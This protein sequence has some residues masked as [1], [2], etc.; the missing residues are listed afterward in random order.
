MKKKLHLCCSLLFVI[1]FPG[2]AQNIDSLIHVLDNEKRTIEEQITLCKQITSFYW[3]NDMDKTFEYAERGLK[4]AEK[5]NDASIK[6]WFNLGIADSYNAWEK[7]D[8]ALIYYEKSLDQALESGDDETLTIAYSSIGVFHFLRGRNLTA[9]D[10]YMR[11]LAFSEITGDSGHSMIIL[12]NIAGIYRSLLNN[13]RALHF[14]EQAKEIAE[15][16]DS[17]YGKMCVYYDL[18]HISLENKET[19]KA[20]EYML[21]VEELSHILYDKQFEILSLQALSYIYCDGFK[22]YDKAETYAKESLR[23]AEDFGSHRLIRY[24]WLALSDIYLKQRKYKESEATAWKAW[25]MD[26]V[27]FDQGRGITQN[28]AFANALMGNDDKALEFIEKHKDFYKTYTN[29]SLQTAMADLEVKYESEKKEIRIHALEKERRFYIW[30][31][32]A[33]LA[34]LLAIMAIMFYRNR[35]KK[36]QINQLEQEK[37]LIA[38]QAVL[39]GEAAE[40]SRLGRDLHDGLGG[41]LSVV[42]L[43]LKDM[44]SASFV[45]GQEVNRFGKVIEML[46]ESINELRR[47]AHHMMPESLMRYGLKVSLEDYCRAITIAH[48]QYYGSTERLDERLEILLY[49]CS[50][51]L[52]NNAIKYA[53]A[54]TI[55]VQLM[56]DNGFVSLT[57]QDNGKGFDPDQVT[58]GSGLN[59]IRTRV[60]AYN[61]KMILCA[62]PGK[63]TEVSIEIESL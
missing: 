36:Q 42:K 26:S 51:E 13:E 24:G 2:Q 53:D 47:V 16:I 35:L 20:L 44:Q 5:V 61:G 43:Q 7:P 27:N 11:A 9:L 1:L 45:D 21:E 12:S 56:A 22:A 40:R 28:I 55:N 6:S 39:D 19:D 3:D 50:Y 10:Y 33:G 38:T 25:E 60:S 48:F 49:R 58:S 37:Q 62:A 29:K 23:V 52:I 59:N 18:G 15:E 63:G 14:L 54:T 31:G 4:L 17:Q 41:L 57:V 8:T 30:F 32:V 34:L 46:D